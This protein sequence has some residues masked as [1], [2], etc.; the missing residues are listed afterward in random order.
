MSLKPGIG[1]AWFSKF[2]DSV[3][4]DD[5][6]IVRGR[7]MRPPRYYDKLFFQATKIQW[8]EWVVVAGHPITFEIKEASAEFEAI[9]FQ[10]TERAKK[11]LDDNT[12]ERLKV[13][14]QVALDKLAKLK[15]KLS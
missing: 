5:H 9:Q 13:K 7:E 10:R 12:P 15:R 6:V 8:P 3:Y 11:S 1:S 2:K 4:P 14:E